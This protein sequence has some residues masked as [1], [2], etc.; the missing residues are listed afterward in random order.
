MG[1]YR[2]GGPIETPL[3]R[4]LGM[5]STCP[6]VNNTQH[7]QPGS[8][9]SCQRQFLLPTNIWV[10]SLG[11]HSVLRRHRKSGTVWNL[12]RLYWLHSRSSTEGFFRLEIVIQTLILQ[13][14]LDKLSLGDVTVVVSVKLAEHLLGSLHSKTRTSTLQLWALSSTTTNTR[15][16]ITNLSSRSSTRKNSTNV[17]T[18]S[19]SFNQRN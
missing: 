14:H 16:R 12:P 4:S 3:S 17:C 6:G 5:V 1:M 10:S 15:C 8:V 2:G 9:L 7:L 13:T 11:C 18:K 19:P